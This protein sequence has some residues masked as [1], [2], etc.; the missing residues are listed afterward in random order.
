MIT[1]PRGLSYHT[2]RLKKIMK[3][4][5]SKSAQILNTN[6][7]LVLLT[8][9]CNIQILSGVMTYISLLGIILSFVL[10]IIV[11]GRVV[12][13][14]QGNTSIQAFEIFKVNWLNYII[15]VILL[16]L[17]ILL[18]AQLSKL[19]PMSIELSIYGKEGIKTLVNILAIYVLPIVFIKRQHLLAIMAGVVFFIQNLKKSAPLIFLVVCIFFINITAML[20]LIQQ[21]QPN[22]SILSFL[23]VMVFVNVAVTYLSFLVFTA[24]S[25]VLIPSSQEEVENG[26]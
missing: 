11:Y 6:I 21:A 9:I 15:A 7:G 26:A 16:G 20:W 23:P 2:V 4:L 10:G 5:L 13:Q 14:I 8:G 12:A 25:L 1:R 3:E 18:Y 17:P 19:L 22:S 24:A